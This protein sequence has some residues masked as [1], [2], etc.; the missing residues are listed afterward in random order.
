MT[1]KQWRPPVAVMDEMD[2]YSV[3]DCREV[4]VAVETP[5]LLAPVEPVGPFLHQAPQIAQIRALAP[6]SARGLIW[7][8]G[9]T[10][11]HAQVFQH[12]IADGDRE[13]SRRRTHAQ[14]L[15]VV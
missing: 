6:R 8:P 15:A 3:D 13:A 2:P 1:E 12:L 10:E 11:P 14:I 9:V 7:P 4:W 5:L